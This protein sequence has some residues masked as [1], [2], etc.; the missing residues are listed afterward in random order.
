MNPV[1]LPIRRK[2]AEQR[3]LGCRVRAALDR[4]PRPLHNTPARL[5][6]KLTCTTSSFR[7]GQQTKNPQNGIA[8]P[9]LHPI[10]SNA[11]CYAGGACDSSHPYLSNGT[12]ILTNDSVRRRPM[13]RTL[14]RQ[15]TSPAM[16]AN[17]NGSTQYVRYSPRYNWW[18]KWTYR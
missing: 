17:N 18:M 11:H 6:P 2:S 15:A 16:S 7:L 3:V 14:N 13:K 4:R 8:S 1:S 10:P 5:A 12:A 9:F